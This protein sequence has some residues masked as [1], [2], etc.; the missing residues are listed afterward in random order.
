MATCEAFSQSRSMPSPRECRPFVHPPPS[1]STASFAS[2][3]QKSSRHSR[4][5]WNRYSRSNV[6]PSAR[7]CHASASSGS[8]TRNR[9]SGSAV[10]RFA[11]DSRLS[12]ADFGTYLRQAL[13]FAPRPGAAASASRGPRSRIAQSASSIAKFR[14]SRSPARCA[15]CPPHTGGIRAD[16]AWGRRSCS[17]ALSSLQLERQVAGR[18]T[19]AHQGFL[20][21]QQP[22][23]VIEHGA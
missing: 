5:S 8:L 10:T 18:A 6:S 17:R 22:L 11:R 21:A 3:N 13:I 7:S 23:D 15:A 1:S 9:G 20:L 19:D 2:A 16:I 12:G 14:T 4:D